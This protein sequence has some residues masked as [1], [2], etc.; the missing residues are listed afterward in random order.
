MI[1]VLINLIAKIKRET[2][3]KVILMYTDNGKGEFGTAFQEITTKHATYFINRVPTK[4]LPFGEAGQLALATTPFEAYYSKQPDLIKLK[5]FSCKAIP[6]NPQ[7][8]G[9][10]MK[11]FESRI[12]SGNYVFVGIDGNYIYNLLNFNSRRIIKIADA[13]FNEYRFL[14]KKESELKNALPKVSNTTLV[15]NK[16]DPPCSVGRSRKIFS[17]EVVQ[18]VNALKVVTQDTEGSNQKSDPMVLFEAVELEN[19]MREDAQAWMEAINSEL[20]NLRINDTF[21]I[22]QGEVPRGIKLLS[23]RW[24]L[25]NK[26]D[27]LGR[28][29]RRKAR[30]VIKGYIQYSGIN[31][32]EIFARISRNSILYTFLAKAAAEDL[33]INNMNIDTAFL[34]EELIDAEILIEISQYF[35]KAFLEIKE[36]LMK[37]PQKARVYLKLKK[38]FYGLK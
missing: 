2:G 31:F 21:E 12:F 10:F 33:E 3:S 15:T 17:D 35:K 8:P 19:A 14:F 26:L 25:Q 7:Q 20:T 36:M 13:N 18:Q 5:V 23:S 4:A 27:H 34:N 30:L 11:K 16:R 32:E 1:P 28:L 37:D 24:I 9:K 22:I 6:L 29:I 38:S